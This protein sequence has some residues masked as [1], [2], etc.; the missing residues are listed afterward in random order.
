M[1]DDNRLVR[2]CISGHIYDSGPVDFTSD[3]TAH[4][5]L[6]PTICK[7]PGSSKLLSWVAGTVASG[8]DALFLT[9]F[10]SQRIDYWQALYSSVVSSC[11]PIC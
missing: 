5:A 9:Q 10:D 3:V 7:I 1:K 6:H 4:F 8:L 2:T 11:F